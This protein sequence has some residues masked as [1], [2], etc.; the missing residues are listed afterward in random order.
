M[1]LTALAYPWAEM[2]RKSS[3]WHSFQTE[4]RFSGDEEVYPKR[5][6][7][8]SN[9]LSSMLRFTRNF[10]PLNHLFNGSSIP[11]LLSKAHNWMTLPLLGKSR[12]Q[13]DCT[14]GRVC[15]C[16]RILQYHTKFIQIQKL[17]AENND[18]QNVPSILIQKYPSCREEQC[19]STSKLK[20]R[21][22]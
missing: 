5:Y 22:T 4:K 9:N 12:G 15:S 11:S 8:M 3:V 2:F 19:I 1:C 7:P 13:T 10:C 18:Q 14:N 16:F 17:L 20:M 6:L 21:L